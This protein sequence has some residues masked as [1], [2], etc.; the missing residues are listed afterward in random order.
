MV[1]KRKEWGMALLVEWSSMMMNCVLLIP[2]SGYDSSLSSP[3][4]VGVINDP[5]NPVIEKI[6][7][8]YYTKVGPCRPFND[9]LHMP[10]LSLQ[11]LAQSHWKV[12]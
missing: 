12:R 9:S 11:K 8:M 2:C 5:A 10:F 6:V 7:K 4:F 1:D 3:V